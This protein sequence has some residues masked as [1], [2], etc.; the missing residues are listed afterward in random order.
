MSTGIKQEWLV[1]VSIEPMV[2]FIRCVAERV[3]EP[4]QCYDNSF[5]LLQRLLLTSSEDVKY[6]LGMCVC[7]SIFP[8]EHAW[9]KVGDVYY[10]P[11]LEIVVGDTDDNVYYSV[12]EL[13]IEDAIAAMESVLEY[14]EGNYYPPMFEYMMRSP[15]WQHLYMTNKERSSLF[16]HSIT[17]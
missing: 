14:S 15:L 3:V 9:I 8:I 13:S 12:M 10:D 5:K 2:D 1:E 4:K 7:N 17:I 6:V 11:T 16:S